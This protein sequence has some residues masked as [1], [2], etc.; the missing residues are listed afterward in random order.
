MKKTIVGF[1][2]LAAVFCAAAQ[3]PGKSYAPGDTIYINGLEAL[4]FQ[5]DKSGTHGKAMFRPAMSD[6]MLAKTDKRA[7]KAVAKNAGKSIE[8][9]IA[10]AEKNF[11]K[12]VKK[13][14]MTQEQ[15]DANIKMMRDAMGAAQSA[16]VDTSAPVDGNIAAITATTQDIKPLRFVQKK[17]KRTY[18]VD[19]WLAEHPGMRLATDAD[20][21]HLF[22][23]IYGGVGREY[24]FSPQEMH[25]K[26]AEFA[27]NNPMWSN[28]LAG[29]ASQGM[30]LV[31]DPESDLVTY[32]QPYT[33]GLTANRWME[34]N[35]GYM[36]EEYTVAVADF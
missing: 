34:F 15:A 6:K 9:I 31:I 36:G 23:A 32:C 21:L 13:G 22:G 5:S 29:I 10:E 16:G 12:L 4:V 7:E 28:Y 18:F 25:T 33:H 8:E 20:A 27:K 1:L 2:S 19:E 30:L 35:S 26:A 24:Q 17:Q 3:M 11:A 14:A